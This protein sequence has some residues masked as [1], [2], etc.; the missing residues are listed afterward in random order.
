MSDELITS[1]TEDQPTMSSREIAELVES[2]HDKVKQSIERLVERGV[3]VQPPLGDV[4]F[5]DTMGR[6]RSER[7]YR[8]CKRDSYIV[9]AQLSPEFTARLVDRWEELERQ[10]RQP[11]DPTAF[12]NDPAAMRGA[13]LT[14]VDKVIALQAINEE[15]APKAVAL[16]RIATG[17]E[18]S[19]CITDAAKTLQKQPKETFQFLRQNRWIYRRIGMA[20]DVAYEDKI[21][22]GYLEHKVTTVSRTDGTE[23]TVSQ[24]RVTPKGLV[25]LAEAFGMGGMQ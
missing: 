15:L 4:P 24:V 8:L 19:M 16:D 7:V 9:V 12:L 6:Q 3:I 23:K 20:T 21:K 18:G 17:S 14:Y 25:K 1:S 5:A 10:V 22:A 11:A 2:R 13:L